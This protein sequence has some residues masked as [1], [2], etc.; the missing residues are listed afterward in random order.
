MSEPKEKSLSCPKERF[1]LTKSVL[2]RPEEVMAVME[3]NCYH[4]SNAPGEFYQALCDRCHGC[5]TNAR[6]RQAWLAAM[7]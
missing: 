1:T 3:A 7:R 6:L 5:Q 4:T 2:E